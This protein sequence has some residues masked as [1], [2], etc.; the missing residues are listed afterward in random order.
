MLSLD[1]SDNLFKPL[2]MIFLKSF[3]IA[4]GIFIVLYVVYLILA[5]ELKKYKTYNILL[6][7]ISVVLCSVLIFDAINTG[8]NAFILVLLLLLGVS[9]RKIINDTNSKDVS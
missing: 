7:G 5:A 1:S 2:F 9:I 3:F 6:N 8:R 4:L